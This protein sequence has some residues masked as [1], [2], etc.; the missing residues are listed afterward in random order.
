MSEHDDVASTCVEALTER[1]RAAEAEYQKA[2]MHERDV[3]A[4]IDAKI[5]AE[6]VKIRA[7]HESEVSAARD[8][9]WQ[10]GLAV[11]EARTERSKAILAAMGDLRRAQ[12]QRKKISRLWYEDDI[13]QVRTGQLEV[14]TREAAYNDTTS[15]PLTGSIVIR[16]NK[17]DGT[18]GLMFENWYGHDPL[19]WHPMD[20]R[21][22]S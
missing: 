3:E 5:A 20:W 4:A 11:E 7:D 19:G 17:K 8:A 9:R 12:W 21:P 22:E 2:A 6:A 18:P 14:V 10:A 15:R 16:I 1:L 13:T